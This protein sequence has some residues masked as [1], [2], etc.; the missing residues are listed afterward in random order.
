MCCDSG[1]KV[2]INRRANIAK[3]VVFVNEIVHTLLS[4]QSEC[5]CELKNNKNVYQLI[6]QPSSHP[7][8]GLKSDKNFYKKYEILQQKKTPPAS[9]DGV[10]NKNPASSYS[11][12]QLPVQYHRR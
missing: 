3:P 4:V 5:G 12:T 10:L 9:A 1:C 2:L 7:S 8:Y 6:F 11:P